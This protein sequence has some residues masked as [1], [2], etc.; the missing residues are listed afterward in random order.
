MSFI[1]SNIALILIL[2]GNVKNALSPCAHNKAASV[3]PYPVEPTATTLFS[4][5]SFANS[6]NSFSLKRFCLKNSSI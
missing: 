2:N 1:L 4:R 3:F 6:C 5:L